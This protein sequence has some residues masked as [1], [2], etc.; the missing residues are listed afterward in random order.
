[1]AHEIFINHA[2]MWAKEFPKHLRSQAVTEERMSTFSGAELN[3]FW[4]HFFVLYCKQ[5][6]TKPVSYP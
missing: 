6:N 3:S 1:M 4:C 2:E 5:Y